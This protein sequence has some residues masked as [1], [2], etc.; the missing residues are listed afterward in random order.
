[1]RVALA[2]LALF[3]GACSQIG[4]SPVQPPEPDRP[5]GDAN[6]FDLQESMRQLAAK[7]DLGA[8]AV[9]ASGLSDELDEENFPLIFFFVFDGAIEPGDEITPPSYEV[10][11]QP[12]RSYIAR[13]GLSEETFLAHP[14]LR[15][16]LE[17]H[18]VP[19]F[20]GDLNLLRTTPG[21]AEV[22]VSAAGTQITLTT[23]E[24]EVADGIIY[25][26]GVT[27]KTFCQTDVVY[28]RG[29]PV[30]GDLCFAEMPIVKDFDWSE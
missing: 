22:V 26:N 6:D 11:D 1:M 25:A 7:G 4:T 24:G 5:S 17:A 30:Y 18:L 2:L 3:L 13:E 23:N 29:S 16:F 8:R 9:I 21:S 27:T 20:D 19:D 12:L 14:D 28:Q 10:G 15:R